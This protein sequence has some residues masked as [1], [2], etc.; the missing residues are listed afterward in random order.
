MTLIVE[1]SCIKW[2]MQFIFLDRNPKNK[3][4][5]KWVGPGL[6]TKIFTP[7][8]IQI[9]L[10]NL[11]RQKIVSHD[12][13]KPCVDKVIPAWIIKAQHY[14]RQN[15]PRAYC[16]CGKPDNGLL[17]IQCSNCL[18]WFHGECVNITRYRANVMEVYICER[19]S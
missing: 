10:K 5:P 14:I 13:L 7:Q 17:M 6:I 12:Y 9:Q 1:C 2:G 3:L 16:I 19:C 11:P 18:D 4:C 15:E 8:T